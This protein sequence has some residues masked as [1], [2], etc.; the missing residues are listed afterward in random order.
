M[1]V[2]A[3]GGV[4]KPASSLDRKAGELGHA[5]PQFLPDGKHFLFV[6][7]AAAE[8]RLKVGELGNLRSKT[9][10]ATSSRGEYAPP[11]RLVY[12]LDN[13]L[14][15]QPFDLGRL[16]L[17]GEPVPVAEKVNL[18]GGREN[19]S[20]S[21]VGTIA[22]QSGGEDP[23][24]VLAWID[25]SGH[26]LAV[27]APPDHYSDISFSPDQKQVAVTIGEGTADKANIWII[28]LERGTRSRFTFDDGNHV[29]PVWSPD[30]QW[31]AY[32]GDSS[33][34]FHA[35]RKRVNGQ[36]GP[37]RIGAPLPGDNEGVS[38]WSPDGRTVLT[39][40][41]RNGNWDVDLLD[42]NTGARTPFLSSHRFN[43]QHARI[44]PDG[45]WVTYAS[46]ENGEY[47]VFVSSFPS[48]AG[49]WQVSLHGGR[50]PRWSPD[51][52]A[53]YF[54]SPD[55]HFME[56]SVS[57]AEGFHTTEPVAL[58]DLRVPLTG[59][60]QERVLVSR[61]GKRF[62]ANLLTGEETPTPITVVVNWLGG[63]HK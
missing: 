22:F 42:V 29:W 5:W 40:T 19:F 25:R 57:T 14:V 11:G 2:S 43:E 59:Y 61:D 58:C 48:L 47:E 62:L 30:G 55:G 33:G 39:E 28:D 36:G 50:A 16:S 60:P 15:A 52:K 7:L 10:R 17:S 12:V 32:A 38:S 9:V 37:E 3:A 44:S 8:T 45:R 56:V 63:Q 51:G 41:F 21:Q 26:R 31:I 49:K 27:A 6:G 13:N 35:M 54:P 4:P 18:L 23:G 34:V 24:S 20:T 53:I 1:Q 46:D